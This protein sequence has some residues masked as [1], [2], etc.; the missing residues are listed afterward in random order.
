MSRT[1]VAAL[2]LA[3]AATPA[4]A[5][6]LP[7]RSTTVT[8]ALSA[9][10]VAPLADS[11]RLAVSTPNDFGAT[12]SDGKSDADKNDQQVPSLPRPRFGERAGSTV[13]VSL[14]ATT[15]AMQAFDVHSTMRA[16]DRGA[17][18]ANPIMG[19]VVN[20]RTAFIATKAAV[21]AGTI[22]AAREVAKRNKLAAAITLIAI[23]SAYAYVAHHNYKVARELR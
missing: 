21:A 7:D 17:I 23:N 22:F 11:A 3:L 18:E 8:Q 20:N 1:F 2:F 10:A 16:L 15:A 9:N 13:M 14:Y 5:Q 19:G 12:K 6:E 4:V